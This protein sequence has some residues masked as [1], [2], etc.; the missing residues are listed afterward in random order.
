MRCGK[1]SHHSEENVKGELV[2]GI[3]FRCLHSKQE[4]ENANRIKTEQE[5]GVWRATVMQVE[6]Q[7]LIS[8]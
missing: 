5:V 7:A 3:A 1:N 4:P 6:L 2:D 8:C